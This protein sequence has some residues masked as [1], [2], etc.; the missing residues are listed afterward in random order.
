VR[1][2]NRSSLSPFFLIIP[3][4]LCNTNLYLVNPFLQIQK[5]SESDNRVASPTLNIEIWCWKNSLSPSLQEIATNNSHYVSI[6]FLDD[7]LEKIGFV[8]TKWDLSKKPLPAE[9]TLVIRNV[10]EIGDKMMEYLNNLQVSTYRHPLAGLSPGVTDLALIVTVPLDPAA[11]D[12]LFNETVEALGGGTKP[13]AKPTDEPTAKLSD[14]P[15]AKSTAKPTD[16]P[17]AKPSEKRVISF[18]DWSQN[19]YRKDG[20]LKPEVPSNRYCGFRNLDSKRPAEKGQDSKAAAGIVAED[21][22]TTVKTTKKAKVP[23]NQKPTDVNEVC[24]HST[25]CPSAG[26][27]GKPHLQ[28][29]NNYFRMFPGQP[30]KPTKQTPC[31]RAIC[32]P[33]SCNYLCGDYNKKKCLTCNKFPDIE[34][35]WGKCPVLEKFVRKN[36]QDRD[37][38]QDNA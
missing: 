7:H 37:A 13:I 6:H 2:L 15:T 20:N 35:V 31:T 4:D 34:H 14:E 23:I 11:F 26:K 24:W 8:E 3:L 36:K 12:V 28:H 9:R 1:F 33:S 21:K 32:Q 18:V 30:E 10:A 5:V 29:A 38:G 25:H 22:W 16:E 27:C 19:Y 17:T